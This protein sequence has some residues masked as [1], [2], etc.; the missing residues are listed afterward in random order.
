MS[1]LLRSAPAPL[2][3]LLG[4]RRCLPIPDSVQNDLTLGANLTR[5]RKDWEAYQRKEKEKKKRETEGQDSHQTKK[6][7]AENKKR[8]ADDG[9]RRSGQR[10]AADGENGGASGCGGGSGQS[11]RVDEGDS[12]RDDDD[13]RG[14]G[15]EE[16]DTSELATGVDTRP[17]K[18]PTK[19]KDGS[20]SAGVRRDDVGLREWR[21]PPT[22]YIC[23]LPLASMCE[24]TAGSLDVER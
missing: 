13:V 18:R 4:R 5:K 16:S 15:N 20:K 12:N 9:Q 8:K 21:V 23:H 14:T 17:A 2:T 10:P 11:G 7:N 22:C 6:K 1:R 19:A 24:C 3:S